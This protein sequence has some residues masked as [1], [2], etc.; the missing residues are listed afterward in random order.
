MTAANTLLAEAMQ[1]PGIPAN[2]RAKVSAFLAGDVDTQITLEIGTA[3]QK[4]TP[5]RQTF[6]RTFWQLRQ[7]YGVA[8]TL[9]QMG[10]VLGSSK[11]TIA[12][13]ADHLVSV[14]IM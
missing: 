9:Q 10:D 14:G 5:K 3:W 11:V 4:Q 6:I 12:G 1:L 7:Q 13:V 8:P 2:F